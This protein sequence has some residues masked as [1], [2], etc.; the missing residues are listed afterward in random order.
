MVD[1]YIIILAIILIL[2]I[3]VTS[4]QKDLDN[5]KKKICLQRNIM[6]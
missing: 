6:I 2:T 5:M 4:Q 3:V 1:I